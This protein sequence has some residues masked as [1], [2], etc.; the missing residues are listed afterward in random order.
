MYH[1]CMKCLNGFSTGSTREKHYEYYGRNSHVEVKMPSKK[2]KWLQFHD[3]KYQFQVP[4]MLYADFKRT[5]KPVG[6]Q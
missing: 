5:S 6:E 1:F 4:L 3:E 2:E